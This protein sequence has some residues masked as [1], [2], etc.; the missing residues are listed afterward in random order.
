M[1]TPALLGPLER[2]GSV[3]GP[4]K[5]GVSLS[6][7]EDGNRSSFR[8]VVFSGYL[9]FPTMDEVQIPSNSQGEIVEFFLRGPICS[10]TRYGS[11]VILCK[12]DGIFI[13]DTKE[14]DGSSGSN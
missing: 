3:T 7:P 12:V 14:D 6:S 11:E 4:N 2:T 10:F 13:C 1:K 5:L 8:K 9:E